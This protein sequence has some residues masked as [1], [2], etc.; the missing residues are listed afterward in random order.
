MT[1][2][3]RILLWV[4]QLRDGLLE[5]LV[6]QGIEIVALVQ[7]EHP[8][9][10]SISIRDLFDGGPRLS[11]PGTPVNQKTSELF[12]TLQTKLTI[13]TTVCQ[14]AFA[15]ITKNCLNYEVRGV[16]TGRVVCDR[17]LL[18]KLAFTD[19]EITVAHVRL[20]V[21][22]TEDCAAT[23]P[24]ERRLGTDCGALAFMRI[25]ESRNRIFIHILAQYHSEN[26]RSPVSSK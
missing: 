25:D 1:P 15:Q 14:K 13:S 9:V 4:H 12:Q 11:E 7:A 23:Q 5:E 3:P 16:I 6:T 18:T 17:E 22:V 20:C 21:T 24:R 8:R 2:R 26:R 10:P 19:Q